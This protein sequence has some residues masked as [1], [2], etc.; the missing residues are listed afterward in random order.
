MHAEFTTTLARQ[1]VAELQATAEAHRRLRPTAPGARRPS[2]RTRAGW[3]LVRWGQRLAPPPSVAPPRSR[4][5]T[6][7]S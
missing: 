4:P 2:L 3:T 5:A 1:H 7:G 6:M